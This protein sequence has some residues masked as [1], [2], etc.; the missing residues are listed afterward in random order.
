MVDRINKIK[1]SLAENEAYFILSELTCFYLTDFR[2]TDG[3][4]LI[5][6]DDAT[7]LTDSRY[8]EAAEMKIKHCSVFQF[9]DLKKDTEELMRK[10]GVKKVYFEHQSLSLSRADTFKAVALAAGAEAVFDSKLDDMISS[11]RIIKTAQEIEKMKKAQEITELALKDALKILKPGITTEREL[12]LEIEFGMR[13]RG[14]Q[15]VAFDLITISGKKTSMPHGEPD[16]KIIQNGDFITI[17]I[18]SCYEGY[19]SDMTRTIPVGNVSDK[20]KEIY[21]IVLEA[22]LAG[23]KAVKPGAKCS[24][25]DKAARDIIEKAGY[26]EFFR[27]STGHGVG[28]EIHEM[29]GVSPKSDY[30]LEEGMVITIEPGIYLPDEFGVRIEDMVCVTKDGCYNFATLSKQFGAEL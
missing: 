30:V 24:D 27:H 1:A 22:Q 21:N 9:S 4:M 19:N 17:D 10:N 12:A 7:V 13:R 23:L 16:D 28:I 6:K 5:T 14:A 3:G 29:P 18:G 2:Y 11:L 26:G 20:M 25:C 8:I 15:G